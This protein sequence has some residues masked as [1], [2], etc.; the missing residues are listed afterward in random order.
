MKK[1]FLIL[2]VL[3]MLAY[4]FLTSNASGPGGNLTASGG[5]TG[6]CKGSG[7]HHQTALTAGIKQ[8]IWLDSAGVIVTKYKAGVTYKLILTDTTLIGA[9]LPKH[10][11][12]C[13]VVKGKG[14]T[15]TQAGTFSSLPANTGTYVVAG[16]TIWGHTAPISCVTG[17]GAAGSAYADTVMW[18]APA[19]GSD[20]VTV[21]SLMNNV[22][23]DGS[24]DPYD[25]WGLIVK[26][27]PEWAATTEVPGID[28]NC[29]VNC[30]PNPMANTLHLQLDNMQGVEYTV[31]VLNVE[32]RCIAN[33]VI[34]A[35]TNSQMLNTSDWLPGLYTILVNGG[36][37]HMRVMVMK[38]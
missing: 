8:G 28:N 21:F 36:L 11:F 22:N 6:G 13:S 14:T 18:T 38:Q 1:N 3:G 32:G 34:A 16:R 12:Q 19:A 37:D 29:S 33:A 26:A 20:T 10:G 24:D 15:S 25:T 31:Q 27:Y 2:P 17:T 4:V 5:A 9:V 30:F 35:G 7:C 23:M